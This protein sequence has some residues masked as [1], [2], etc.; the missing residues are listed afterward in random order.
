MPQNNNPDFESAQTALSRALEAI[1]HR[2]RDVD[3]EI[4]KLNQRRKAYL[5]SLV[6]SMLPNISAKTLRSLR[7]VIPGFLSREVLAVFERNWTFLGIFHSN[8]YEQG[9]TMLQTR[10]ASYL[11]QKQF[12]K[13]RSMDEE[14]AGKMAALVADKGALNL[15]AQ[16]ALELLDLMQKAKQS[17][18]KLPPEASAQIHH[19]ASIGRSSSAPT[20]GTPRPV[21]PVGATG[22]TTSSSSLTSSSSSS[23]DDSDL[24]IYFMTDIPT[25]FRTLMISSIE[26][27][28]ISEAVSRQASIDASS[29][30]SVSDSSSTWVS[31]PVSSPDTSMVCTAESAATDITGGAAAAA[32]ATDDALGRFS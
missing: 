7:E 12:G 26:E 17:N 8:S 5:D 30:A 9:Y 10:L 15:Q 16:K 32:I 27:H 29:A 14:T 21:A 13:L 2:I 19:I 24:W 11:D 4:A 23:S 20:G 31:D 28:R 1:Q 25:S 18:I 6:E 22:T 3:N